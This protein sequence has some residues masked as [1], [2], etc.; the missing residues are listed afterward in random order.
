MKHLTIILTVSAV[1]AG[2]AV[3]A[4]AESDADTATTPAAKQDR[5]VYNRLKTDLRVAHSKLAFAYKRAVAEARDGEGKASTTTRAEIAALRDEID[6][7]SVRL[8]LVAD[9]HGWPMPKYS[10]ED[11]KDQDQPLA[12]E[13]TPSFFAPDPVIRSALGNQA[14]QLAAVVALPVLS[15]TEPGRDVLVKETPENLDD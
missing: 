11:F 12:A 8:M 2:W 10:L 1:L 3:Q 9:R 15:V 7:K 13:P 14:Q 4:R 5:A 6:R